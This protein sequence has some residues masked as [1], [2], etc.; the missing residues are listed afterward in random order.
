[1]AEQPLIDCP[2]CETRQPNAWF[3]AVCG[4][5]LHALPKHLAGDLPTPPLEE[6]ELTGLDPTRSNVAVQAMEDLEPTMQAT[7]TP[8]AGE[9]VPDFA[10]T[11]LPEAAAVGGERVPDVE[12]TR[13]VVEAETTPF[14]AVTCRI[15]GTPW[16]PGTSRIC[17]GCGVR[18]SVPEAY[19]AGKP[20]APKARREERTVC[21]SCS[22]RD[23]VV[24]ERC[25]ACGRPVKPRE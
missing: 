5:A 15:C 9:P 12:T 25:N 16:T 17:G 10:P 4:R 7:A 22:A 19:L 21:P 6:L 8:V 14:A 13:L 3:C 2:V 20:E 23:Q 18:L 24:G 11:A 1:M